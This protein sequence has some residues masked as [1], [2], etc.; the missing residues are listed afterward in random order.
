MY[1][2]HKEL[3][4]SIL[5]FTTTP[6]Q[7]NTFDISS[8]SDEQLSYQAYLLQCSIYFLYKSS[9]LFEENSLHRS[10]SS[11]F[12]NEDNIDQRLFNTLTTTTTTTTISNDIYQH[13]YGK[14]F[15]YPTYEASTVLVSIIREIIQ[16]KT[17]LYQLYN[18]SSIKMLYSS[19]LEITQLIGHVKQVPAIE[20]SSSD[21][22]YINFIAYQLCSANGM[23]LYYQPKEDIAGNFVYFQ[24]IQDVYQYD[25]IIEQDQ[26]IKYRFISTIRINTTSNIH[27]LINSSLDIPCTCMLLIKSLLFKMI[28]QSMNKEEKIELIM[29]IVHDIVQQIKKVNDQIYQQLTLIFYHFLYHTLLDNSYRSLY[30]TYDFLS[31]N[32]QHS[33]DVISPQ[34]LSFSTITNQWTNV[35][36]LTTSLSSAHFLYLDCYYVIYI[37][38]N[39]Q[40]Q[41]DEYQIFRDACYTQAIE[42]KPLAQVYMINQN[43]HSIHEYQFLQRLMPINDDPIHLYAINQELVKWKKNQYDFINPNI[44]KKRLSYFEFLKQVE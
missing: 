27:K 30:L 20:T 40:V 16:E 5:I 9:E 31:L 42:T 28:Q 36:L 18:H 39:L 4:C 29:I 21:N 1:K 15:I 17:S 24:F 3:L 6:Y 44:E 23:Y 33:L 11:S 25:E 10:S 38:S 37:W 19:S 8:L 35:P 26:A 34:L 13:C 14:R 7:S 12:E 43:Q 32:I 22:E 2:Q 41:T